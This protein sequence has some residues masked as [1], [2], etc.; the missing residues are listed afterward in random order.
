MAGH[1]TL[2]SATAK[3]DDNARVPLQRKSPD[4]CSSGNRRSLIAAFA[5]RHG[6]FLSLLAVGASLRALAWFAYWPA[7]FYTDSTDYLSHASPL[8]LSDW[9]PPG[10]SLLLRALLFLHS[11]A[12]VTLAQHVFMLAASCLL[13]AAVRR[14]SNRPRLAALACAPLLLDAYQV[15]IEQYVM[16]GPLFECL[17]IFGVAGALWH[18]RLTL[19]RCV[20]IAFALSLSV[21]VRLDGLALLIPLLA[22]LLVRRVGL[23]AVLATTLAFAAPVAGLAATR[24]LAGRG[25]NLSAMDSLWLYGRVATFVDCSQ[26]QVPNYE[27]QLCP[28]GPPSARHSTT[29]YENSIISPAHLYLETHRDGQAVVLDFAKRVIEAQPAAYGRTVLTSYLD[30]FRPTREQIPGGPPVG[31]WRFATTQHEVDAENAEAASM[32][33][34]LRPSLK[35]QVSPFLSRILRDYQVF[36]YVPGPLMAIL[37]VVALAAGLRR[38]RTS[39]GSNALFLAAMGIAIVLW[40][41][42]TVVFS[43]R[44]MLPTLILFPAAVAVSLGDV[45]CRLQP[46][47]A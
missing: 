35:T 19:G 44:Y 24:D 11:T 28:A 7:L 26:V 23:R 45:V 30:Q 15:Q 10:Y 14:A 34:G 25:F 38:W 43:W 31:P 9:H 33:P 22:W 5:R 17:L 27:A 8:G 12:V 13:Y 39:Q 41:C 16:P 46:D 29:W 1:Q 21:I 42:A 32:L 37:L 3:T 4:Q 6:L 47:E 2:D 20:G 40:A 36:G 18:G